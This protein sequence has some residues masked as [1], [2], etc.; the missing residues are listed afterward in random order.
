MLDHRRTFALL[1][2]FAEPAGTVGSAAAAGEGFA[3]NRYPRRGRVARPA[4]APRRRSEPPGSADG[5]VDGQI[6]STKVS[7]GQTWSRSS[8]RVISSQDACEVCQVLKGWGCNFRESPVSVVLGCE[9]E[10]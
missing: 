1:P 3:M 6:K 8:C 2:P 5:L 10:S 9:V 7:P 4:D